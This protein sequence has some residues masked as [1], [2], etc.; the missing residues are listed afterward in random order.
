M[1]DVPGV[2]KK[3]APPPKTFWNIFT[4]VKSFCVKFCKFVGNS[5]PHISTKFCRF[6]LIFHQM[7]LIFPRVPI[8]WVG[9]FTQKINMQLFKNDIIF[10][11]RVSQCPIIVNNWRLSDFFTINVLLTL[12]LGRTYQCES[13]LT[14]TN[15]ACR[16]CG[17]SPSPTAW[18]TQNGCASVVD[19]PAHFVSSAHLSPLYR[20]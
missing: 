9:L 17:R 19:S 3:V 7:V 1:S 13:C 20:L 8:V 6:I 15:C 2:S 12:L 5:Y 10:P 18:F 11:H 4:S 16:R 14:T